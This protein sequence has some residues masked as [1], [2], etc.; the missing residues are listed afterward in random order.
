[1]KPEATVVLR[2][3]TIELCMV[4]EKYWLWDFTQEVNLSMRSE[5]KEAAFVEALEYYQKRLKRVESEYHE[6]QS[7]VDR[8]ME[9]LKL[10]ED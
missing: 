9:E 8:F 6:L 1:M 10:E 4:L 2:T 5:T 7:K 3:E